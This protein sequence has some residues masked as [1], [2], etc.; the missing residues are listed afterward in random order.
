MIPVS[1]ITWSGWS[2]L[3]SDRTLSPHSPRFHS[4]GSFRYVLCIGWLSTVPTLAALPALSSTR[5]L[6]LAHTS[7]MRKSLRVMGAEAGVKVLEITVVLFVTGL[8]QEIIGWCG[9]HSWDYCSSKSLVCLFFF[10]CTYIISWKCESSHVLQKS[11][12]VV[13]AHIIFSNQMESWSKIEYSL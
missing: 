1:L 6:I 10:A 2:L 5:T 9:L 4:T 11:L 3:P 12:E 8:W 7:K 13:H